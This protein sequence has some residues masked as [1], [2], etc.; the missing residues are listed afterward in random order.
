MNH[1]SANILGSGILLVGVAYA[2]FLTGS[3]EQD[4]AKNYPYAILA[5][6]GIVAALWLG[7]SIMRLRSPKVAGVDGDARGLG[8]LGGYLVLAGTLIYGTVV[9]YVGYVLPTLIYIAV[10]A[11]FLGG[12]NWLLMGIVAVLFPCAIYYFLVFGFDRPLPF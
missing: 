12:R 11:Y 2:W 10:A 4:A 7:R 3:F 1:A 9:V 8:S 6:T 5:F